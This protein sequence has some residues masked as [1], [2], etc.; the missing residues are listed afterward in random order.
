MPKK[1]KAHELHREYSEEETQSNVMMDDDCDVLH[2]LETFTAVTPETSSRKEN[3]TQ[4]H[5]LFQHLEEV[6]RIASE[7]WKN[8]AF[9][10]CI[11]RVMRMKHHVFNTCERPLSCFMWDRKAWSHQN[12]FVT[13]GVALDPGNW[14]LFLMFQVLLHIRKK[15]PNV[16]QRCDGGSCSTRCGTES[17]PKFEARS[18]K[19]EYVGDIV[20]AVGGICHPWQ[21]ASSSMRELMI[22]TDD[23]INRIMF[24]ETCDM[25]GQ[26]AREM[27][28]FTACVRRACPEQSEYHTLQ[29]LLEI[30]SRPASC[31]ALL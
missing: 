10:A 21:K 23:S 6:F 19:I 5:K 12:F 13:L 16:T 15:W 31:E 28:D 30:A 27:K 26:L 25:M 24:V 8:R 14:I 29:L 9:V 18:E 20:E 17:K 22:S 3:I 4:T 7:L 1:R 2:E 11:A